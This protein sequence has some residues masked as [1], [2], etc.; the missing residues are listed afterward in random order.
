MNELAIKD[1][2][3]VETEKDS[4]WALV[5]A[6]D[7]SADGKFYY[8]VSTTG[9]YC[10]PSCAARLARPEHVRFHE[11]RA[12]AEEA[13]FRACKRCKPDQPSM[14]EQHAARIAA[15][16]RLIEESEESPALSE[17]ARHAGLSQYHFHRIFKSLTGVTPKEYAAAHRANR[18]RKKLGRSSTIT[19]A[20]Y[21]AGYN[22]NAR[23]YEV[24]D[25]VLGMT[26]SEYRAGGAGTVIRFAVGECSL[27]S[28]LVAQ[29]DRGV[30]AILLGDDPDSLARELQDRFPEADLRGG[31]A[32][33]EELVAKVVG[34]VEAPTLGL[35]LPLDVRGT[36]FQ[37]RVWQALRDIPAGAT[38]SYSDIAKRIGSPKSVR[39]VAQA[40][41]A[42]PVAVAIPCH[43]VV[44]S[45]GDLSGYRW[46]VERKRALLEREARA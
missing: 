31:N 28:I 41:G 10:R 3:A 7:S 11:T 5:L 20:I 35:D 6:R 46:G 38:A 33:F 39:A 18:L 36:T 14:T 44:R 12:A 29:S 27:G 32:E 21:D 2:I 1:T 26:A 9:V 37:H 19:E 34:F 45:D 16:C 15:V 24:S 23:F 4:R 13:G 42:N 30:C 25:E 43:R 40:C 17:L 8:S 22:S